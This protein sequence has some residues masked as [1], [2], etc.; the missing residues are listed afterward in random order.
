ML[1]D[2]APASSSVLL[3]DDDEELVDLLQNYWEQEG[4]TVARSEDGE[5]GVRESTFWPLC[6]RR[7]RYHDAAA[8]WHRDVEGH[9]ISQ[10]P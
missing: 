4:F 6:D 9:S 1:P 2:P 5:T 7:C 10:Q 8:E 3:V